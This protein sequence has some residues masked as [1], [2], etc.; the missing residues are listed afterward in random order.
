MFKKILVPLDG[1]ETA[2]AILPFVEEIA[3]QARAEIIV[4]TAVQPVAV[5]DTTVTVTVLENEESSAV[6]YLKQVMAKIPGIQ[7]MRDKFK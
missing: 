1:S 4:M 3:S 5:W 2:E 7:A 6:D